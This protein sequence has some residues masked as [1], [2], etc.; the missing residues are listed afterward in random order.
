MHSRFLAF[1][2]NFPKDLILTRYVRFHRDGFFHP[3]T[4]YEFLL[5][6][7]HEDPCIEILDEFLEVLFLFLLQMGL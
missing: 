6:F 5:N 4:N 3:H 2:R 1:L 7:I